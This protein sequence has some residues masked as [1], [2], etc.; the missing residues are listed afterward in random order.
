MRGRVIEK[1]RFRTHQIRFHA[2]WR[3]GGFAMARK[4]KI[5]TGM[6]DRPVDESIAQSAAGI[7][8]DSGRAVEIDDAQVARARASL[9]GRPSASGKQ[10]AAARPAN[11][12]SVREGTPGTGENICRRCAG[13]G[14]IDGALCPDCGGSGKVITPI[15]GG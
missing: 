11:P 8:D 3:H 6:N 12:E 4:A 15:G 14:E 5:T 10:G 13:T 9:Q 7:P 2:F 1:Y